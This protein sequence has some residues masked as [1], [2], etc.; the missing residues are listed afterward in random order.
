MTRKCVC[1]G[2]VV[3]F[4]VAASGSTQAQLT[5]D[6]TKVNWEVHYDVDVR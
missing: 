4:A 3:I 1:V 5:I 2:L 6:V